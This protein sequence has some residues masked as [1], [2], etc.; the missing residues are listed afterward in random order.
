MD[1]A[2]IIA[3]VAL[4]VTVVGGLAT[5]AIR[6]GKAENAHDLAK[7]AVA[8]ANAAVSDLAEFKERVARDYATANMVASVEGRVVAAI[9]R[10]GDRIDRIL[11]ARPAVARPRTPK[12]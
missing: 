10:L 9:D 1:G 5:W 6:F 11:E 8:T 3:L 4:S 2:T 7:E 12:A